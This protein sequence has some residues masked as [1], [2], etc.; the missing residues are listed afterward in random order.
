MT[1]DLRSLTP[2][3]AALEYEA[4]T[5]AAHDLCNLLSSEIA[6]HERDIRDRAYRRAERGQEKLTKAAGAF[7]A[8][9]MIAAGIPESGGWAYRAMRTSGF[10]GEDVGIK[11]FR[12]V[13]SGMMALGY[14]EAH[15]DNE[16]RGPSKARASHWRATERLL[17][18]AEGKGIT[19]ANVHD[20]FRQSLPARLVVLKTASEQERRHKIRGER[21]AFRAT[22]QTVALEADIRRLNEF[23]DGYEITGGN[24]R[25]YVRIFN[26]GTAQGYG[27]NQ[28]GRLFSLCPGSYQNMESH[29]RP[30]MTIGGEPVVEID[31][32]ASYLTVLHG[33][34]GRP[35][36]PN[37]DA[38][39]LEGLLPAPFGEVNRRW[40]AKK[41]AVVAL[42]Q[43]KPPRK[44]PSAIIK[45]FKHLTGH[46]LSKA[47][48]IK[49]VQQAM[50]TKHPLLRDW[51]RLG[52]TWGDLMYHE[53][54]AMLGAML[55]L[56]DG[57]G[58]P[59]LTVHDS[60]I[61]RKRDQKMAMEALRGHYMKICGIDPHLTTK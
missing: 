6:G 14:V 57:H 30:L 58:I 37:Q 48:P 3:H 54:E 8:D 61:V 42:G 34:T 53:S 7:L 17:K 22:P 29:L 32:R 11:T 31:V 24:H 38:Y 23:L 51:G 40:V 55:E 28:G 9:L 27:W 26:N 4:I 46:K 13:L 41:W 10:S 56:M 1:T 50:E 44:W 59:S 2:H 52:V 45:E 19:P 5:P 36:D 12:I 25:G 47:Y 43:D 18:L 33:I 35:F 60:L 21:I 20:H 15:E 39:G 16:I 49:A